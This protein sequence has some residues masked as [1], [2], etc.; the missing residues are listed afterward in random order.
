M[1]A[2]QPRGL[3]RR[4]RPLFG[5]AATVLIGAALVIP[6]GIYQAFDSEPY[7]AM[8]LPGGGY[9]ETYVYDD[10]AVFVARDLIGYDAGGNPI[11]LDHVTFLD[12]IPP[13]FLGGLVATG[14]GQDAPA[15]EHLHS[16]RL[17][18]GFD[19][20]LHTPSEADQREA[21]AWLSRRLQSLGLDP[22]RLTVRYDEVEVDYD[23]GVELQRTTLE[24]VE[25]LD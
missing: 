23:T 11:R 8:I 5:I 9:I 21:R 25:I 1:Q 12:P 6:Y 3:H 2:T 19:A 7:P 18:W 24:E 16:G 17:D 13:S 15:S 22:D 20:R 10:R 4:Q 14:F